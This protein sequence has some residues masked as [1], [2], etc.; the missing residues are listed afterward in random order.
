MCAVAVAGVWGIAISERG[1]VTIVSTEEKVLDPKQADAVL[2]AKARDGD[3]GAFGELVSRYSRPVY[4]VVS[5]MVTDRDDVDDIA[6]EVFVLAYRSI[7]SFRC[8]AEFSTWVYRIA[9]NTTIKQMKRARTRQSFSIDDPATGLADVL[10]SSEAERPE[11]IAERKARNE[12]LHKAV[13]ELPDKHRAV[14]VL[15]YYENL[16]CDEIARV[17]ECSV[18][19]VWSRLHYACKRL[20]LRLNSEL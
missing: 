5:R 15:H 17:L 20:Q 14:V 6:Q 4:G 1:G 12:A 18:G 13:L 11:R 16:G 10:V 8:E 2:V 7:R 3:A 19:T 9:V